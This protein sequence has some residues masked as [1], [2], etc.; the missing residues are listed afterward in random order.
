[1][2]KRFIALTLLVVSLAFGPVASADGGRPQFS[3]FYV[4]GDSLSDPG[5]V[6]TL[7]GMTAVAP[8]EPIPSAPYRSKRFTNGRVWVERLANW[9]GVPKGGRPA[10]LRPNK[11][12]NYAL[13]GSRAGPSDN[14]LFTLNGQVDTFLNNVGGEASPNALYIIWFGG[15]DVRDALVAASSDP[16][17]ATSEAIIAAGVQAEVAGISKLYAA[18]ARKFLILNAPNV[19]LTP[20]VTSQGPAAVGGALLLSQA[21]NDGLSGALD[22]VEASAPGIEIYRFDVFALLSDIAADPAA[23]RLRNIVDACLEF[24]V[25]EDPVCKRPNRFLFWD[26]IHPT[27]FTHRTLAK[28]VKAF[29]R[30]Q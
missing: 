2:T 23:F 16:T 30:A 25:V 8:F 24:F 27:R 1:M 29:L 26:A 28:E 7:T 4:F 9:M 14:P 5:N 21:F 6:F 13:G 22:F 10:F 18:G 19:A 3:N 17:F 12:G 15:N 20:A 11:F